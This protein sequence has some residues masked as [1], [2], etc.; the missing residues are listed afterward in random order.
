MRKQTKKKCRG[1]APCIPASF[2]EKKLEQKT[3]ILH[4]PSGLSNSVFAKQNAT[5]HLRVARIGLE[6]KPTPEILF[7]PTFLGIQLD[8]CEAKWRPYFLA[9]K[10]WMGY[11]I[12]GILIFCTNH[13]DCPIRLLRSKMPPMIYGWQELD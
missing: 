8:F 6:I 12:H 11:K 10:S 9:A 13:P 5:H 7:P 3:F 1:S 4:Q 2:F